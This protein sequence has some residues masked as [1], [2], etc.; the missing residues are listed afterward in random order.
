MSSIEYRE[1]ENPLGGLEGPKDPP[2]VI[3]S[4]D[5][6]AARSIFAFAEHAL[7]EQKCFPSAFSARES[8]RDERKRRFMSIKWRIHLIEGAVQQPLSLYFPRFHG[9]AVAFPVDAGFPPVL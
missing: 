5:L 9:I 7:R 2:S 1:I 4:S 3:R 8:R 6:C